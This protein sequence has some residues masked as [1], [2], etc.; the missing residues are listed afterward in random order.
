MPG[1]DPDL[2]VYKEIRVQ[3]ALGVDAANYQAAIDLLEAGTYPFVDLPRETA[4]FDGI[5]TLVKTMAGET[6][7]IAPVHAV[8][9]P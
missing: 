6:E 5:E 1:F 3:C 9:T 2:I 4:G 8:F 7:T